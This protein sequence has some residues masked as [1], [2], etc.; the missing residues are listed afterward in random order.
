MKINMKYTKGCVQLSSNNTLFDDSWFNEFKTEEETNA[1]V[2][3]YCGHVKT[4]HKGFCPA[5]FKNQ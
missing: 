4:S 2:V 1:E 5:K 3:D